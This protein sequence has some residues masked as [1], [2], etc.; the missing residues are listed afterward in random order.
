MRKCD[1]VMK[2]GIT[3]GIVYPGAVVEL[4]RSFRFV[5]IGGTSAGAIAAALT[6]AAEF[7]RQR[8]QS[9]AGFEELAAL[10]Q[11]LR[12][13]DGD[14]S[15]LLSLFRP[16]AATAPIFDVILAALETRG[17]RVAR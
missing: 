13:S 8:D 15:R 12:E 10:P 2:G 4:A 17:S 9:D 11:W 3:S 1:L 7:R 5:N 16:D 14:H 6:A